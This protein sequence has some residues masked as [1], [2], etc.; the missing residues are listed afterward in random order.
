MAGEAKRLWDDLLG[1]VETRILARLRRYRPD[2]DL[3]TGVLQGRNVQAASTTNAGATTL[4]PNGGTTAGTV[5]QADDDRLGVRTYP[6]QL[7]WYE[8]GGVT[9]D[10]SKGPLRRIDASVT[11]T[12]CFLSVKTAPVGA[13]LIVD[14]QKASSPNGTF[15][16]IFSA[17]PQVAAGAYSGN[18]TSFSTATLAAGDI[19]RMDVTQV[20]STTPGSA[21]TVDLNMTGST[22]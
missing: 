2:L 10:T 20:G 18:S 8:D 1:D 15:A 13:A 14:I 16:T 5:V 4:A 12:G 22:S 9:V 17:L 7:S 19:L 21:L 11:L 3:A 6:R